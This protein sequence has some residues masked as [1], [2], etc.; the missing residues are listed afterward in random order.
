MAI[1]ESPTFK[2]TVD[3]SKGPITSPDWMIHGVIVGDSF[4]LLNLSSVNF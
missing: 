4:L 3:Q 1:E 2:I